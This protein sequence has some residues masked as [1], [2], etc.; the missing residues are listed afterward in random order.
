MLSTLIL[1]PAAAYMLL[2]LI[3]ARTMSIRGISE[4]LVKAHIAIFAFIAITTELLSLVQAIAFHAVLTTWLLL[5]LAC[6]AA[7]FRRARKLDCSLPVTQ[8]AEPLTVLLGGAIAFM[9][10]TTFSAAILYPPNTWD[11]MTYHMPK[12]LHWISNNNVSFYPTAITRQN[13][14]MPLAE[15]AIMHLQILTDGDVYANLVQW[16]SF[17]VLICL[18]PLIAAEFGLSTRQQLL[19]AF[20]IATLPMAILQ[21][22]S[23]QNDLVV[24]GFLMAFALF[25]LRLRSNLSAENLL[26]SASSLGL[27]L[28]TKGT[29]Y[30]Y[31]APIG[32]FLA[33][34][35]LLAGKQSISRYIKT[36]AALLLVVILGLLLNAGHFWRNYTQYGHPLSTE[37]EILR[38]KELS[39]AALGSTVLR[40]GALHLATP[41]PEINGYQYRALELLLGAQLNNPKTTWKGTVF[42]MA[43]NR[44]EDTAGNLLHM[45][46][47][48]AGLV[49]LPVIPALRHYRK[50][51]WYALGLLLGGLLFC[52]IL[53]WQ[54]WSSRLHT[55][56]FAMAAPLLA[57][58]ITAAAGSLTKPLGYCIVLCLFIYS[59]PFALANSSRPLASLEWLH[60]NRMHLY[61]KNRPN[62]LHDYK[63]AINVLEK[64]G[65]GEVGLYLGGDDWE[66]PLWVLA[67]QS[68]KQKNP[69]AFRHVGVDA[70]S[71][72]TDRNQPLPRYVVATK[73][74]DS[75]EHAEEYTPLYCSANLS[76]FRKSGRPEEADSQQLRQ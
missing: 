48:L 42:E 20:L 67:G 25:M 43:Y 17:L 29:A 56:L 41:S 72:K 51:I 45:L 57:L 64:G 30:F 14:Q 19:S 68:K 50:T 73:P 2:S 65:G 69:I 13:Y 1:L 54:P 9:L 62:L 76:V 37:G 34:A 36:I 35:V 3:F 26:L 44:S 60:Y 11:S 55:P 10:I 40:N 58:V 46:I 31:G 22:S 24:A 59:L 23:T 16:I 75:W 12:V 53:K 66:Y 52:L 5:I 71:K 32:L 8:C 15:F 38:S 4:A 6:C 21:A 28:L 74:L 18:G 61:F 63:A 47:A 70:L 33:F 39:L 49:L 27:A 7:V